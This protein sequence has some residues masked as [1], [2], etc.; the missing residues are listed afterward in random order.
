MEPYC[1]NCHDCTNSHAHS[2]SEIDPNHRAHVHQKLSSYYLLTEKVAV[3]ALAVFAAFTER[4]KFALSFAL[5]FTAGIYQH[6]NSKNQAERAPAAQGCSLGLLER[7]TNV[8]FHPYFNLA[9]DAAVAYVHIDHHA[10]IF[11]PIFGVWVGGWAGKLASSQI[12][13]FFFTNS[14]TQEPV[15]T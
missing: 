10:P 1:T 2:P 11:V 13:K 15:A 8:K 4:S 12:Q 3:A 5:G 7:A 9:S 14:N 6:W